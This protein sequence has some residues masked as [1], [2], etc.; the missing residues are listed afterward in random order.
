[1]PRAP[2]KCGRTGCEVRVV[3]VAYCPIH[4]A[5]TQQRANTTARDY[6][7]NHQRARRQALA[8][9]I[10][11]TPCPRCGLPMDHSQ[12]LDLDHTDDRAGYRG[13]AHRRCNAR[14]GALSRR[15]RGGTPTPPSPR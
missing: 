3:G 4:L 6:G 1:M 15:P 11:G 12:P 8:T 5:E 10:D 7:A 2:K 9:L 14:A 13:L